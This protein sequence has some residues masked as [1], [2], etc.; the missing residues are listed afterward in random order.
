MRPSSALPIAVAVVVVAASA[1]AALSWRR[2]PPSPREAHGAFYV[3]ADPG[4]RFGGRV[5]GPPL[6]AR[7]GQ[8]VE[9]VLENRDTVAHDLWVVAAD[10]RAPYLEPAFPGART[11]L[12]GP[13]EREEIQFTPTRPGRYRYVCTVPGHDGAMFGEFVVE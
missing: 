6:R 10:E 7:V 5:P 3:T 12:L 1:V 2:A 8:P 13:G 9:V 4:M 11:R